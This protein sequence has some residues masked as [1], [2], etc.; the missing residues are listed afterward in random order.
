MKLGANRVAEIEELE[1]ARLR[2]LPLT[3]AAG[4]PGI[5]APAPTLL[6]RA[7][8]QPPEQVAGI[9]LSGTGSGMHGTDS[10]APQ[11]GEES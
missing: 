3:L 4:Q 8:A 10:G 1:Q 2:R 9:G 6:G 7:T 11:L 5:G